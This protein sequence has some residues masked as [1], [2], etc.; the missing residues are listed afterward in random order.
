M[1]LGSDLVAH[2]HGR[3]TRLDVGSEDARRLRAHADRLLADVARL[4]AA[5]QQLR[6]EIGAQVQALRITAR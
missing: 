6:E 2:A 5:S 4:T 3:L 1:E